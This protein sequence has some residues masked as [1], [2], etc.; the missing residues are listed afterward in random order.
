MLVRGTFELSFFQDG[1]M[2]VKCDNPLVV[3]WGTRFE[4][5]VIHRDN[6]L[7]NGTT[8]PYVGKDVDLNVGH[9]SD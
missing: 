7:D 2:I 1:G 3:F 4:Y 8:G 9:M 6:M 5:N